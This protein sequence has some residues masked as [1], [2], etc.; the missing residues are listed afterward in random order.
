MF[1]ALNIAIDLQ[2]KLRATAWRAEPRD[3]A[4]SLQS[5]CIFRQSLQID[6]SLFV[7]QV[8][9]RPRLGRGDV[10]KHI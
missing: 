5:G 7:T 4:Y 2:I 1:I 6:V 10:P 8:N 9:V 3:Q